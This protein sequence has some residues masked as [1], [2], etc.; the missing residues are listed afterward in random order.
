MMRVSSLHSSDPMTAITVSEKNEGWSEKAGLLLAR[1]R[2]GGLR[3][4]RVSLMN[5]QDCL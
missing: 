1:Y 2:V 3:Q 5:Q 4:Y